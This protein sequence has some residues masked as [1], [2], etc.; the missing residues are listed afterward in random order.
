MSEV[1]EFP[2]SDSDN[3]ETCWLLR[4]PWQSIVCTSMGSKDEEELRAWASLARRARKR[5]IEEEGNE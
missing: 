1:T 4:N 3:R 5:W 2:S